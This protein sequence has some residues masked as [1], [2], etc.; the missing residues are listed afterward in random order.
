MNFPTKIDWYIIKKFIGTFLFSI[1]LLIVIVIVFDISEKIDDFLEREAPMGAIIFDYYLN[2]IPYFI[3][4]FIYLFTFIAVIFF[5]SKLAYRTEIV[6]I[7]NG[8]V[9]FRRFLVPYIV[10]ASFIGILS[11]VLSN[12][13]IPIT[14]KSLREFEKIYWKDPLVNRDMNIHM[15][16][17]PDVFIYVESFNNQTKVGRRFSLEE[18]NDNILKKRIMADKISWQPKTETWRLGRYKERLFNGL[19]EQHYNRTSLDTALAFRPEEFAIDIEDMKTMDWFQLRNFLEKEKLKGSSNVKAY[20]VEKYQ[21]IA[22][23]FATIILTLIGVS[24]SSRKV[25]GGMGMHLGIGIAL[26]FTYILL[27]QISN[28]FGTQGGLSPVIAVWIPN[29]IFGIIAIIL[30]RLAPK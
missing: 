11:F 9:S 12:F 19:S 24:L 4:L 2:F 5:T 26:A 1:S 21:R 3:N 29:I 28:M 18:F 7:L 25:R 14:N 15:Q 17:S 30:I 22:F 10:A 6:A 20:E 23:P 27:M 8:G 16:I 13:V